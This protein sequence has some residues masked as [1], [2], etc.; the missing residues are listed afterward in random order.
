MEIQGTG[1][2]SPL[3]GELIST[4]GVVTLLTADGKSFWMQDLIGDEDPATS[5]GIFVY[6]GCYVTDVEV[7]DLVTVIAKVKEYATSSRPTDLPLTELVSADEILV[8]SQGVSVPV[9]VSLT[10]LPNEVIAEGI[11]FWESL[12]G[13]L[14]SVEHAPVVGPTSKYGEFCIIARGNARPGSGFHPLTS[15]IVIRSLGYNEVDYNP[16]RIIVDDS[17]LSEPIMA[18]PRDIVKSLIGVVDYNYSNYKIQPVEVDLHKKQRPDAPLNRRTG[19]R[20]N[21]RITTFNVENLFD[22]E[23]NP[24]K[25][26]KS[27]TPTPE[28]LEIKLTKLTMAICEELLLPD[29]LVAQEVENTE[30]LQTLA[31]RVN[32]QAGTSYVA[33]SFETSDGRGIEVG[34]LYDTN[35]VE[36]LNA[37]QMSGPD[38]EAAFGPSSPSPGR[39][40]I[41][42]VF[43]VRGKEITII[44]N[45]F[46]SKG[47]D[48]PLFGANWPPVR[49]TEIQ[50]KAQARVVRDF[51]NELFAENLRA[52]VVVTG[53]L[54][55]FQ[56]GEPGEGSD[57]PVG[58]LEGS[59]GEIPL[60]NLVKFVREL[61]RFTY[62]YEGNSQVLD[63]ML[64]SPLLLRYRVGVNILH[65]NASYPDY[66]KD[67]PSIVHRSSDHDAVELRLRL[68]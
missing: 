23:N 37:Y 31:D 56:F 22:L 25:D 40:P 54:N 63:H 64:I 5:D 6:R 32:Q 3:E 49:I 12:E 55:D 44:G 48:E 33:V 53:D 45:H 66:M 61:D 38:V 11:T 43:S 27:S 50:R 24:E 62:L 7:G 42:G 68:R 21:V 19:P 29:I 41:V 15:Q 8:E 39:E 4:T 13:M 35:T 17:S 14:V 58:I 34:F 2:R 26:D 20:G 28:E 9:P 52:L 30:I 59:W 1:T 67:D 60:I 51:V 18:Q 47:G 65:F 57:H 10:R 36:L 46:K 16:E